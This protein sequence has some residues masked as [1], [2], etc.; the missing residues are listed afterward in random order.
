LFEG[1]EGRK[2]GQVEEDL[3]IISSRFGGVTSC[4]LI[5]RAAGRGDCV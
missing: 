1:E 2:G 4:D 3:E 5:R